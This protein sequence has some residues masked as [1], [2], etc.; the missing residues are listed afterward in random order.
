MTFDEFK[1]LAERPRYSSENALFRVEVLSYPIDSTYP[2][3]RLA[4]AQVAFFLNRELAENYMRKVMR[5]FCSQRDNIYGAYICQM[6]LGENTLCREADKIWTYD[7]NGELVSESFSEVPSDSNNLGSF[8]G[9]PSNAIPFHRG[10][11][12]EI[13][14]CEGAVIGI[15]IHEPPTISEAWEIY[16]RARHSY[17]EMRFA[18]ERAEQM[19]VLDESDDAYCVLAVTDADYQHHSVVGVSKPHLPIPDDMR[20]SLLKRF[21]QITQSKSWTDK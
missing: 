16:Q 12:V 18:E 1:K 21:K 11:L 14:D 4:K 13:I 17:A 2:V 7:G 9:R 5:E 3:I 20:Q 10:D 15:I 6:P 8:R 19:H